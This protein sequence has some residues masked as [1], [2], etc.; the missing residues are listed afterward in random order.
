MDFIDEL[1]MANKELCQDNKYNII[2]D[3]AIKYIEKYNNSEKI[4]YSPYYVNKMFFWKCAISFYNIFCF[5][6]IVIY[7]HKHLEKNKDINNCK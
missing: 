4:E 2:Y 5:V 1:S 6:I 3:K 7:I